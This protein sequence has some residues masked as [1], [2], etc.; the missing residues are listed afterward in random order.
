MAVDR[1]LHHGAEIVL[2][3]V[4][5]FVERAFVGLVLAALLAVLLTVLVGGRGYV[6]QPGVA[7]IVVGPVVLLMGFGGHSPSMRLGL[8]NPVS[9]ELLPEPRAAAG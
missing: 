6:E 5:S 3:A 2:P 1:A 7:C 8:R 4:F 9:R